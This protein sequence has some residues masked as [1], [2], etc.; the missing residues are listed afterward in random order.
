MPSSRSRSRDRA[1]PRSARPSRGRAHLRPILVS[2]AVVGLLLAS[3]R[4]WLPA[5]DPWFAL[6]LGIVVGVMM[7]TYVAV[8]ARLIGVEAPEVAAR[9]AGAYLVGGALS[10]PFARRRT[11]SGDSAS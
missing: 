2:G 9:Q 6:S 1:A 5:G 8:P 7:V 10:V 3:R 4:S 11:S